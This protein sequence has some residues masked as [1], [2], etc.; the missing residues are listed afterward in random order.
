MNLGS[1]AR[2]EMRWRLLRRLWWKLPVILLLVSFAIWWQ[3]RQESRERER[4]ESLTQAHGGF[5]GAWTGEVSY[6]RG[7]H[8]TEEFFFQP[9]GGKLFGTA[10][11]MGRKEGIEEGRIIEGEQIAFVVRYRDVSGDVARERKNYYWGRLEGET[12]RLRL[13]DDRGSA[14]LEWILIRKPPTSP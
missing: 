11:F 3:W 5:T 14:P 10:S 7:G 6:S 8:F 13:Q 2:A 12:I 4:V 9:E 1:D